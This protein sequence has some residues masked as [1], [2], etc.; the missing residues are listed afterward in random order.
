M[1]S[2]LIFW[3]LILG[4]LGAGGW[5]TYQ[6]GRLEGFKQWAVQWISGNDASY[7]KVHF[8]VDL[9]DH[10]NFARLGAK[11]SILKVDAELESWLAEEFLAMNSGDINRI[12]QR[13][14]DA[15][16][17]YAKVS[18]CMASGPTL[19]S[20]LDQFHD[21]SHKTDTEMTHLASAVR[22][23]SGGLIYHALLVVGQRL[24]VFSPEAIAGTQD[25]SFFS[26]CSHCQHPH[27]VRISRQ[28]HSLGLE[29][30]DCRRTYAVVASDRTG[31]YRYVNEFLTGYAPPAVFAKDYSRVHELFTIWSAVHSNCVYTK[32]PGVG[33]NATD[34][35]QTSLE[36][37]RRGKGDCEDSAIYLCDWLLARGFQA[38]VA[39]GRYGD[40]GGH[41]W[42]V[43]RLDDKE[44]LLESTEGRPD[45]SN[46][47]LVSRVGS[48]YVPEVMFDRYSLFVR[49]TPGQAWKGD[50][51][52]GKVW[53]K[54]EPRTLAARIQA[55]S[56]ERN[57]SADGN[58]AQRLAR[59]TRPN[60]AV[61]PFMELEEIPQDAD[62][63]QMPLSLGQE[64]PD[65]PAQP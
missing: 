60:P 11:Q 58:S 27:I 25:E 16:P 37:Q 42:V 10:L 40:M 49:A 29:C 45:P 3:S 54:L 56:L 19:R 14:Q 9:V 4:A 17:R 8:Q 7:T 24:E 30:P 59:T 52:S 23:S 48:R 38:R 6:D 13:I 33:K 44:Y 57:T 46:P 18:V 63:W 35:W 21:F 64:K 51:W 2:R 22:S 5:V 62:V 36:T 41:A 34:E 26:T 53:A 1:L 65:L 12:T 20:L 55:T 43:V 32:D 50:Y 31:H 39:L 61:A 47:P 28:P 15:A